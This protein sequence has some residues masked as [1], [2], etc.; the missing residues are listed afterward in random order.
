MKYTLL[1]M[2]VITLYGFFT[3]LRTMLCDRKRSLVSAEGTV[4]R[5]EETRD[6]EGFI[7]YTPIYEYRYLGKTYQGRHRVSSS[8]YAEN[9][10]IK[11]ATKY[12]PGTAIP[13]LI[14]ENEPG[15]SMVNDRSRSFPL[16]FTALFLLAGCGCIIAA[17]ML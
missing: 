9:M 14:D 17:M 7:S 11:A 2:G 8:K 12:V 5:L 15:F 6:S 10:T 4:L 13:I 16:I 1:M 3:G